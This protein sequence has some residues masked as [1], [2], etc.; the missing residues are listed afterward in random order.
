MSTHSD[1]DIRQ[2]GLIPPETLAQCHAVVIGVGAIGRQVALQ[3]AALGIPQ[4]TL[5]DHDIVSVENLA[6]QGY[7]PSDLDQPKVTATAALCRQINP[8]L[9]IQ[10]CPERFR[11]S[12]AR[13]L[14]QDNQMVILSCVDSITTR[15]TIFESVISFA[16]LLI[17]GRMN[18]E[19]IRVL[20]WDAADHDNPYADSLF[21]Q[22]EAFTGACTARST[23]YAASIAAGLMVGQ[24]ARWL[25][26]LDVIP[27]QT[28]NLLAGELTLT[29]AA[30]GV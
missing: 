8:D 17:D 12:L 14:V 19:V 11:R 7:W 10:T 2:R 6:P 21:A 13:A 29:D 26:K 4:L 20:G 1:R 24:M 22:E 28:L 25:R 15:K 16:S 30:V 3:M 23:I 27:D 5:I 18:A 9:K